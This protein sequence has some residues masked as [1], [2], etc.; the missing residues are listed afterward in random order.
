MGQENK[1]KAATE[2]HYVYCLSTFLPELQPINLDINY[3]PAYHV[4]LYGILCLKQNC[5]SMEFLVQE[6]SFPQWTLQEHELSF[7]CEINV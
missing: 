1:A 3:I 6:P 5:P 2:G 4:S 7:G